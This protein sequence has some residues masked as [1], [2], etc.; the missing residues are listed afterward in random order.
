MNLSFSSSSSPFPLQA[1]EESE[2]W[3]NYVEYL[4]DIVLDGFF[5]CIHCSLQYLLDNT[6][7]EKTDMPP[8]MEAK[9][10]LQVSASV[11]F[12]YC[13]SSSLP[14]DVGR[15]IHASGGNNILVYL[16]N[17]EWMYVL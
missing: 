4:D 15:L 1:E 7:K 16:V 3:H 17:N 13:W 2:I 9:F 12:K 14:E 5:N 11:H 8:L 6:N 10:E